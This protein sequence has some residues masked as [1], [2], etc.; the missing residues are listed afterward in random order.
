MKNLWNL[1]FLFLVTLTLI[2]CAQPRPLTGG[3]KD[4]DSPII[5]NSYPKNLSTHYNGQ[6]IIFEFDEYIQVKSLNSELIVSPPLQYPVEYKLKGKR[7]VFTIKDTLLPNTTYNFNFGS[8]IVDLNESNPLDSNLFVISTGNKIDSGSISGILIDAYTQKPV[9]N[10]TVLLYSSAVD[11]AIYYGNPSYIAKT[12]N[13]GKYTLQYLSERPYQI[14]ALENPGHEFKYIPFTK[15]GFI[16][17]YV[18]P[19]QDSS[20]K[21][22]LFQEVDTTQYVTTERS[23][24]YYS[25]ILGFNSDLK[26]PKFKIQPFNDTTKYIIEEIKADSFIFWIEGDLDIDTVHVNISDLTGYTDTV[27]I[28]MK[29]RKKFYKK[30][31]RKQQTTHP[32]NLTLNTNGGNLDYFDSIRLSFSRPVEQWD[33]SKMYFV[34]NTDTVL[35]KKAMESNI[36]KASSKYVKLGNREEVRST[37]I[38]HKW[39]PNQEYAFIFYPDAF[40]DILNQTNDTTIMK[41]KTK[42]F[43]DYGSFRFT[44]NVPNYQKPLLMQLLDENGKFLRDYEIK[45]GD[46]I[47][48]ELAIPGRY[49]VRLILDRNGN[50]KWDTGN[51][52]KGT[53]PEEIIYYNG[54]IEIRSNWDMEET[55]NVDLK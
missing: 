25:F 45:S 34:H 38:H 47:Y 7:V 40:S 3:Q 2:R 24:N 15:V 51:L 52:A 22:F 17:E 43:E 44:V 6:S 28:A 41:F 21:L 46:V 5:K 26:D 12:N 36:I 33:L 20:T 1:T 35:M 19:S 29:D 55:W 54:V 23:Q 37:I 16:N 32:L 27:H 30:L 11:S 10:A 50:K 53:Q 42:T 4:N 48:H 39:L 9:K 31:K 18:S 14:F 13:K 49:M 8:A